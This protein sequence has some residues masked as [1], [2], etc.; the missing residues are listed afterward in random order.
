MTAQSASILRSRHPFRQWKTWHIPGTQ[1]TLKGYSRAADKTFFCIPELRVCLDAGLCEGYQ[2]DTVFITHTHN[3]H[4]ADLDYLAN[5]RSGVQLVVPAPAREPIKHYLNARRELNVLETFDATLAPWLT[6]HG[7]E[8]GEM[9]H[10]GKKGRYEV[11]SFACHHSVACL[12]YAF[13]ERRTRLTAELRSLQAEMIEAG[14]GGEFGAM[15]AKRRAAGEAVQETFSNPLFVFLGDT[16]ASV[17]ESEPWI[18]EYPVVIGECTYLHEADA[19]RAAAN[20]HTLWQNLAPVVQAHPQTHFVLTHFS[21]RH[22]DAEVVNF[23]GRLEGYEN[24]TP[25]ASA[26]SLLPEQHQSQERL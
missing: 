1:L 19:E 2:G 16:R 4:I 18:L 13:S 15:M 10:F 20:G 25:W 12:G 7:L 5:K 3:D 8:A 23:F 17:F 21:L 6:M 9:F 26:E 11:R 24:V 14:R 22:S